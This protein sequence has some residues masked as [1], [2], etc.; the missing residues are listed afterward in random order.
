MLWVI[1]CTHLVIK[2]SKFK[3]CKFTFGHIFICTKIE[4]GVHESHYESH[5]PEMEAFRNQY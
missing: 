3:V 1:N 4:S 5:F 2:G